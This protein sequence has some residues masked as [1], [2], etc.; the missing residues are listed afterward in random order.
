MGASVA[1]EHA[2]VVR[3]SKG[4]NSGLRDLGVE[5]GGVTVIIDTRVAASVTADADVST[6]ATRSARTPRMQT[7]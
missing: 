2:E 7:R 6:C 5:L 1:D 4:A 3:L